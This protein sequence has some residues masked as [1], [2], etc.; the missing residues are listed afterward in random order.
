LANNCRT[1]WDISLWKNDAK[2]SWEDWN[3]G[4]YPEEI[5]EEA[6]LLLDFLQGKSPISAI[7]KDKRGWG[8]DSGLYT[9]ATGY[10][11]IIDLP[12]VPPNPGPWK[13]LWNFPSIPKVDLFV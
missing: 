12:W 6:T 11:A 2:Q 5:K 13:A 3:L 8:S 7:S 9:A 10:K 1:L 4:S